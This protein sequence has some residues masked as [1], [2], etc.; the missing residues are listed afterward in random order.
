MQGLFTDIKETPK[1]KVLMGYMCEELKVQCSCWK[2]Q[3]ARTF[4]QH[5]IRGTPKHSFAML[6]SYCHVL[7]EVNPG[8]V[9]HIELDSDNKFKYFFM[10]LGAA[11]RGF[12]FMRKVIGVDEAWIKIQHKRVLLIAATQDS[13]NHSYPIA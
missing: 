2:A 12:R 6:P 13:E 1:A 11:I 7:K 9:T 5:L 4:A 8:T 3:K 10:A